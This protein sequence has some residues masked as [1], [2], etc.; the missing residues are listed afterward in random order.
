[1]CS[2]PDVCAATDIA[3]PRC[4]YINH[5][6]TRTVTYAGA[7]AVAVRPIASAYFR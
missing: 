4:G 2:R 5:T 6:M 1:M 7:A 3:K